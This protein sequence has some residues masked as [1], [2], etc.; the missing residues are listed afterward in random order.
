MID[1]VTKQQCV[2][3]QTIPC[4]NYDAINDQLESTRKHF[5]ALQAKPPLHSVLYQS[6]LAN[7]WTTFNLYMHFLQHMWWEM[8]LINF[9]KWMLWSNDDENEIQLNI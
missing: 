7:S 8:T 3:I 5:V 1:K 4:Q 6:S 2:D 9:M